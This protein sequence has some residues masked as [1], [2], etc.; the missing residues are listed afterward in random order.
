MIIS[1]D[2]IRVV[3][4]VKTSED[5]VECLRTKFNVSSSL[6]YVGGIPWE[7]VWAAIHV[8]VDVL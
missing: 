8:L 5:L 4:E 7:D 6:C 2:D 3:A 1:G